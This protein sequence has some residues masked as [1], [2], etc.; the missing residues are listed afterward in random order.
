MTRVAVTINP[1]HQAQSFPYIALMQSNGDTTP[2]ALHNEAP[3]RRNTAQ[4]PLKI[5]RI[6][7]VR[8][9]PKVRI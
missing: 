6:N 4:G 7:D 3:V 1:G 5:G 2:H 9:E 8:A